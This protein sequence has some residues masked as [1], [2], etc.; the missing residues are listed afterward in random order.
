MRPVVE[1]HDDRAWAR[2]LPRGLLILVGGQR[3]NIHFP[4]AVDIREGGRRRLRREEVAGRGRSKPERRIKRKSPDLWPKLL[5]GN[6]AVETPCPVGKPNRTNS[7]R[8]SPSEIDGDRTYAG[9]IR[10]RKRTQT[11]VLS[12]DDEIKSRSPELGF[13]AGVVSAANS[14]KPSQMAGSRSLTAASSFMAPV[15]S[16][17]RSGECQ[18]SIRASLEETRL[19]LRSV[20]RGAAQRATRSDIL[21]VFMGASGFSK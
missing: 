3:R 5:H 18:K 10:E 15:D 19:G 14:R 4:I 12:S 16:I 1:K 11:V 2:R 8:P 17:T 21:L 7:S 6:V 20:R 9:E 13:D